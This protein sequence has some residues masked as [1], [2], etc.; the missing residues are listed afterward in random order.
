ML[1]DFYQL[2]GQLAQ[3]G[4]N[5]LSQTDLDTALAAAVNRY[6]QDQPRRAVEDVAATASGHFLDLPAGWVADFSHLVAVEYPV[7]HIPPAELR[8][9]QWDL[10]A[11]PDGTKLMIFG[12]VVAGDVLR[13]TYTLPHGLSAT[14][15]TIPPSHREPVGCWA[16][17]L[18]CEQLATFYAGDS[19][20]SLGADK[21]DFTH[22]SREYGKRADVLRKRYFDALGID[23]KKCQAAGVNVSFAGKNSLGGTRLT[24]PLRPWTGAR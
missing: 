18:L 22:P 5:R 9:G 3:D 16:A 20:S 4:Q 6:S 14:D 15:D 12:G 10:Y 13:L 17:A 1:S 19:D 11:A 8:S 2:V 24:H 21:V 7:G 23:P